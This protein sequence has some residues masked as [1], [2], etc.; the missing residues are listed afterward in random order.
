MDPVN[1][2]EGADSVNSLW[3]NVEATVEQAIQEEQGEIDEDT[4]VHDPEDDESEDISEDAEEND[5][6]G[7][8]EVSDD[9]SETDEDDEEENNDTEGESKKDVQSSKVLKAKIGKETLEIPEDA[10]F[11]FKANGKFRTVTLKE[12]KN[13]F[14]GRVAYDE[15]LQALSERKKEYD[16]KEIDDELKV[17]L[18]KECVEYAK[19]ADVGPAMEA[20]GEALGM[21]QGEFFDIMVGAFDQFF[22][23]LLNQPEEQRQV[24]V[25]ESRLKGIQSRMDRVSKTE[26]FRKEKTSYTESLEAFQTKYHVPDDELEHCYNVLKKKAQDVAEKN[27]GQLPQITVES[28]QSLVL[29]RRIMGGVMDALEEL[30]T[31]LSNDDALEIFRIVKNVDPDATKLSPQDYVEIVTAAVDTESPKE[32]L[33]RK[34][35][36]QKATPSKKKKGKKKEVTAKSLD[37]LWGSEE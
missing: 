17:G 18:Y 3:D 34:A 37:A 10:S 12:L 6:D 27:G 5:E 4:G 31:E 23:T 29:D 20:I 21:D 35:K 30:G 15:K 33:R 11:R 26:Q 24:T 1:G 28:I 13:D 22:V 8:D 7:D 32:A 2:V 9:D 14:G 25:A 16:R 19:A 36:K